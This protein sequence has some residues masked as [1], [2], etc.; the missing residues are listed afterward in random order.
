MRPN[1]L[2]QVDG[3]LKDMPHRPQRRPLALVHLRNPLQP[4]QVTPLMRAV[5]QLILVLL[6]KISHRVMLEMQKSVSFVFLFM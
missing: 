2:I 6:C 4:V 5:I 3:Y 1:S